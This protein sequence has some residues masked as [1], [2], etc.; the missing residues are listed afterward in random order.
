MHQ[1][2]IVKIAAIPDSFKPKRLL[3]HFGIH[4]CVIINNSQ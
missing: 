4:E 1:S 2:G 3:E